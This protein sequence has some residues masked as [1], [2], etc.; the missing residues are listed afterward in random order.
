MPA[1]RMPEIQNITEWTDYGA[2]TITATTTNPTKGTTT[3]DNVKCREVGQD[4]ECEYLY[5]QSTAGTAGSGDIVI[6]LPTGIEM[7][8]SVAIT[9]GASLYDTQSLNIAEA[10]SL[11]VASTT[12]SAA[13][14][15][16]IPRTS[17]SFRVSTFFVGG[18]SAFS[19]WGTSFSGLSNANTR[20][21]TRIK[22]R[23]K[24][25]GYKSKVYSGA[26]IYPH[27]Q[28]YSSVRI[29]GGSTSGGTNATYNEITNANWTLERLKGV[30]ANIACSGTEA[31]SG[32]TCTG[33]ESMG[34]SFVADNPGEYVVCGHLPTRC[35]INSSGVNCEGYYKV[36]ETE[37]N[38]QVV[39]DE[40]VAATGAYFLRGSVSID[41][42]NRRDVQICHSFTETT[43]GTKTYRF[44]KRIVSAGVSGTA[45]MFADA[46]ATDGKYAK[47]D[48]YYYPPKDNP[49]IGTFEGIEK[50]EDD[51]ECTDTFSARIDGSVSPSTVTKENIDWIVGDCTRVA[52]GN[53]DCTVPSGL[54]TTVPN[55]IGSRDSTAGATWGVTFDTANSTTTNLKFRLINEAGSG[56]NSA[57]YV[58]CQKQGS[59]YKPKTAKAA[60]T[61]EMMY[62][63][64]VTRP[65]TC[66]Y[67]FGGASAT[68][69]SP[70]ACAAS[71]CVE[72]YDSC[73]AVTAPTRSAAGNYQDLTF[74]N[75]TWK[76][77]TFI[78]CKCSS[79]G[80][81][82]S[83][84]RYCI[85]YFVT[86]DQTWMTNSS[87]GAVLNFFSTNGTG[88]GADTYTSVECTGDA[89]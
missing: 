6:S 14:V 13:S 35:D 31:A 36:V 46:S 41:P 26:T 63:P 55:C 85:S 45:Y 72:V 79:H 65:K 51:F 76:S 28:L 18:S 50:C 17:T 22:F 10:G 24:N 39:L 75:G 37:N 80:T 68:L 4:Y 70:T 64:N 67:A 60:T 73:S 3:T 32:T 53:F 23:G 15:Y 57:F 21:N 47:F 43:P 89:P 49:I 44:F 88:S 56:F 83:Q 2:I 5:I 40:S 78:T 27:A 30:S 1:N 62:V 54:F 34:I 16:A 12:G 11:S 48:V 19:F 42:S 86:S 59:D 33:N 82:S 20:F 74:A 58:M 66:Y 29:S 69:A 61:N 87:G 81:T 7:D 25:L 38:S 8:S 84:D 77:D 52:N 71:P 9:T